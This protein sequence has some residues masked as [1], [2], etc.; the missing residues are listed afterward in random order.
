[1]LSNF[2][3]QQQ[4]SV[5]NS[6]TMSQDPTYQ[7]LLQAI[8]VIHN[9]V[10]PPQQR[11]E[12]QQ[13]V[14]QF[15]QTNQNKI[16]YCWTFIVDSQPEEVRHFGLQVLHYIVTKEWPAVQANY[17]TTQTR[18]RISQ[19]LLE[20]AA[21][22]TKHMLEEKLFIK[23]KLAS[24][25]SSIIELTWPKILPEILEN[26]LKLTSLGETQCE[27]AIFALRSL[28]QDLTSDFST[29]MSP[30]KRRELIEKLQPKIPDIF[31]MAFGLFDAAFGAY[32]ARADQKSY[33][34]NQK[35]L[36]AL[37][38]MSLAF[39]SDW[40]DPAHFFNHNII[41]IWISLLH[42]DE[43]KMDAGQCLISFVDVSWGT[44]KEVNMANHM[45]L[46]LSKLC[47]NTRAILSK[48]NPN[49]LEDEYEFHKVL[50]KLFVTF[51][52]KQL[53][54]LNERHTEIVDNF[55]TVVLEFD[56]HPS[57]VIFNDTLIVWNGL[58]S[59]PKIPF[60]NA[61]FLGKYF[62]PLLQVT[63]MKITKEIGNPDV[64]R[65]ENNLTHQLSL[66]DFEDKK[67]YYHVHGSM[68]SQARSL[69]QYITQRVPFETVKF[70]T[71]EV[72]QALKLNT[73]SPKDD[74]GPNGYCS[75]FSD[76]YLM[77]ESAVTFYEWVIESVTNDKVS[78]DERIIEA[79]MYL[80]GLCLQF[81]TEDAL[82]QTIF[83][84]LFKS[85][86]HLNKRNKESLSAIAT[87]LFK[88]MQFRPSKEVGKAV[89]EL[90][91]DTSTARQKAHTTFISLCQANAKDLP[92][93]LKQFV[94][95][96]EQLWAKKEILSN[97]LILMY[98]A[99]V[100]ISNEWKDLNQQCQFLDYLLSPL[101]NEL[102][103]NLYREVCGSVELLYKSAGIIPEP[104]Q[105]TKTKLEEIK[106]RI[107]HILTT[108]TSLAARMPENPQDM[109]MVDPQTKEIK[110]PIS[111]YILEVLPNVLSL[112]R[113]IHMCY[114]PQGQ[115]LVPEQVRKY[116]LHIGID[117]QYM[118]KGEQFVASKVTQ[119][120][121]AVHKV[122][123][124]VTNLRR[125]SY[126]LLGQ[127]GKYCEKARFWG[128][129]QLFQMLSES[130]FSFMEFVTVRDL[131]VL[132][133]NFFS[134]FFDSCPAELHNTLLLEI[135]K[136]LLSL[137]TA[138]IEQAQNEICD[139]A[140]GQRGGDEGV[141]D[142][143]VKE[144]HLKELCSVLVNIFLRATNSIRISKD[145]LKPKA[146]VICTFIISSSDLIGLMVML[147]CK[148]I[149]A[150]L[151]PTSVVKCV[152]IC[153]RII[154]Y[155]SHTQLQN[156]ANLFAGELFFSLIKS[157]MTTVDEQLQDSIISLIS[158]SYASLRK[159]TNIMKDILI[160]VP[161]L[162]PQ[163]VKHFD[164]VFT[165]T[166]DEKE[167]KK[168]AKA[169][170]SGVCG[171]N[172]GAPSKT[173]SVLAVN[174]QPQS[175]KKNAKKTSFLDDATVSKLGDLFK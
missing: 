151:D 146:D 85:F 52:Q 62:E 111:A 57:I 137:M 99:F 25:F 170:F 40:L 169:L 175:E 164:D 150:M 155:L 44:K 81:S 22:G 167:R 115:Q 43:F 83:V 134:T 117:E 89:E 157:L 56:K 100:V 141:L 34:I 24:I 113:T 66:I 144:K 73:P 165:Q 49:N 159:K 172:K 1:M 36:R 63:R 45:S 35:L 86:S 54:Y 51:S 162:T 131:S 163:K 46:L 158:Y 154:R 112:I 96:A 140:G 72:E 116:I 139:K 78:A 15:K 28:A 90:T 145:N 102:N 39:V 125:L 48:A 149:A 4:A 12:A 138:R 60:S 2:G 33:M 136:P 50:S 143:I 18:S 53:K 6:N 93:Y 5:P 95:Q 118:A 42:V 3:Q 77:W 80:L 119:E 153:D 11:M 68:R 156:Y 174:Q 106:G 122:H 37:L 82:I 109:G 133:S 13:Y 114:T 87:N 69:I 55:L 23:E 7:L 97:E 70:A 108:V 91:E 29:D 26:V 20:Y 110:Y 71:L 104:N 127:A 94:D 103:S 9:P 129:P 27:I 41:D 166:Q 152:I 168:K 173:K 92:E 148:I 135:L 19:L 132:T 124:F 74:K 107:F 101:I 161:T 21:R 8:Q 120:Q 160:Q 65:F 128:N 76:A 75:V 121:Y 126:L 58:L 130:V 123:Y 32:K 38:D 31:S 105:E 17:Q 61:P 147:F 88:Q 98:E 67:E 84:R 10:S 47:E 14:E 64:D 142:E 30:N 79:E 16:E 59:N 171:M